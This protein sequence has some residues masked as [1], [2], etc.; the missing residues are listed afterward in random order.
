MGRRVSEPATLSTFHYLRNLHLSRAPE[1]RRVYSSE[2]YQAF[3]DRAIDRVEGNPTFTQR[4]RD[5]LL[6]RLR[7][8]RTE[9]MPDQATVYALHNFT[10]TL[11][12]RDAAITVFVTTVAR[13]TG[14]G[15]SEVRERFNSL[16]SGVTRRNASD[17][18]EEG[19]E[20]AASLGLPRDPG[21][22]HAVQ[23]LHSEMRHAQALRASRAVQRIVRTRVDNWQDG[24]TGVAGLTITQYGYDARNGRLEVVAYDSAFDQEQVYTYRGVPADVAAAVSRS[25]GDSWYQLVRGRDEYQYASEHEAALDGA[26]PRCPSCGQF[27]NNQ[28]GCP[29]PAPGASRMR[30]YA[31]DSGRWTR[32]EYSFYYVDDRGVMTQQS[33]SA[34][35]PPIRRLQQAVRSGPV[36]I[37]IDYA[38]MNLPDVDA[39]GRITFTPG[40]LSGQVGMALD[41]D[42]ALVIDTARLRCRCMRFRS[43]GTCPHID[44]VSQ[45]ARD[46]YERPNAATL[47]GRRRMQQDAA[48]Q[49]AATRIE[50]LRERAAASDW[51]RDPET[52]AEAAR[53]WRR[54]A[55]VLYSEDPDAFRSDVEEALERAAAKNGAPDI[56]YMTSNALDGLCTRDSGKG[57]GIEIEYEFPPAMAYAD[58]IAA[59][60]RIGRELYAAGLTYSADMQPYRASQRRGVRDTHADENG[61]GNWSWERD[62][63]VEGELVTPIMYDEP[64]TW[65]KLETALRILRDNGAVAGQ[66]AGAHV[67]VGTGDFNG[68]T[69]VYAE[70]SRIVV[71]HEDVLARL[72][73]N[74]ERG[75]HRN[76][77]YSRP[78]PSVPPS[79][80]SDISDVRS[81]QHPVGRYSLL[82]MENIRGGRSDH[83]EFRIFD[84]TLDPGAIQAQIK[85]SVGMTEAAKRNADMGGTSREREP[86]GANLIRTT[87]GQTPDAQPTA[88]S[89]VENSGTT[90]SFIDMLF[91][92]RADKAQVV[93]IFAHTKWTASTHPAT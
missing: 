15:T 10:P 4:Q 9:P 83:P 89:V 64:E 59:Q 36:D 8:A 33:A 41:D 43:E 13:E 17:F 51:T 11:R 55:E 34:Y 63:S 60:Q 21:T 65:E 73:T 28:H 86:W 69:A 44:A 90:R 6:A 46:R 30:R 68:D 31:G 2:D 27:A 82:N 29:Q 22:V 39:N 85:M 24:Q 1:D 7:T 12:D 61:V 77:G 57:F 49:E 54:D 25:P 20:L 3:L 81:W 48:L 26:A 50:R 52:A 75:T 88:D 84:S 92:R 37:D 79:G 93:A 76:N 62:G 78:A 66:R 14:L 91:K 53:T 71:Q 35:L 74:P 56:P 40:H 18:T 58:R 70:L 72:A 47:E 87:A 19:R 67:H 45:M 23:Q 38:N 80:F 42:D 16:A 32:Q 5:S